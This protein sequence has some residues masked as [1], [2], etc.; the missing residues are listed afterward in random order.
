MKNNLNKNGFTLV[1]ILVTI[2]LLALIG[3]GIGVSL[4]KVLKNQEENSYEAFIEKIKSSTLLYSS[5]SAQIVNDLEFN[6]GYILISMNDLIN[7]GYI[8]E[9]VK[10]PN[11]NETLKELGENEAGEDYS[12]ARVYYSMDKEMIVDYPYVKPEDDVYL[13]VINYTTM[14]NSSPGTGDELCYIGLNTSSLGLVNAEGDL[15]KILEKDKNIYAYMENGS[16]CDND[17]VSA[18]NVGTYKIRYIYEVDGKKLTANRLITIKAPKPTIDRLSLSVNT[19]QHKVLLNSII[20]D[21]TNKPLFYC[22]DYSNNG[23]IN[24]CVWQNLTLS[25]SNSFTLDMFNDIL[26]T[27]KSNVSLSKV[28]IYL[29]VKNSFEEY[30][31]KQSNTY[32]QF[33]FNI[34]FDSKGGTACS[35]K[36]L[37]YGEEYGTLCDSTKK[38]YTLKG[39]YNNE[40]EE[41]TKTSKAYLTSDQ[42]LYAKW[43]ANTYTLTYNNQN[44]SGC[45]S[46]TVTYDSTYGTLCTP[47]RSGYT[48]KGWCTSTGG[49][50]ENITSSTKVTTASDHTVYAKWEAN[51][52]T[53]TYNNQNGSGCSSKTVTYDS[54]YGTLC[55][56][57]RSGY[58]FKGWYTSTGGGGT[59]INSSTIV[60]IADNHTIYA[61]WTKITTTTIPPTIID[62]PT[63]TRGTT[64]AKYLVSC[65]YLSSNLS[66]NVGSYSAS[67]GHTHTSAYKRACKYSDGTYVYASRKLCPN[68]GWTYASPCANIY[69]FGLTV[70][71]INV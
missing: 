62:P 7:G 71:D 63:T 23:D 69:A 10:N 58:T 26:K 50:G 43:E 53:L 12:K 68:C 55:T 25:S 5:N 18:N 8:R 42:R 11:T 24:K 65:D 1:E 57:S 15:L 22:I 16:L 52:Y 60:K 14:Y 36:K 45:S 59:K 6:N 9:N 38:G 46:K 66:Y 39:W 70:V 30:A 17:K 29:F 61:K 67:C 35:S 34:S 32:V 37:F 44:G 64:T 33:R 4:N 56:P 31:K 51:T 20:T 54:T 40:N 2:G 47:S 19:T 49:G 28:P 41:I 27:H 48:F 13:N 21:S 3:I